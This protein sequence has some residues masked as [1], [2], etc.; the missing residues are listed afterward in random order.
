M[1]NAKKTFKGKTGAKPSKAVKKY[2]KR[3]MDNDKEDKYL[4]LAQIIAQATA[5]TDTT[6][7][8]V[9]LSGM[10]QGLTFATR[11][12]EVI[13][14]KSLEFRY[15]TRHGGG[16]AG[17]VD[18]MFR[19]IVFQD[20]QIRTSTLPLVAD[21]LET[22]VYNSPLNHIMKNASRFNILHDSLH[23]LS[24]ISSVTGQ[25]ES[26]FQSIKKSFKLNNK[27]VYTNTSTGTERNNVYVMYLSSGTTVG[28]PTNSPPINFYSRLI[29]EDA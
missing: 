4:D 3:V 22:V 28:T 21:I 10:S 24:P 20:R 12:G 16:G 15:D 8:V 17:L 9:L 26:S 27:I 25:S 1:V 14:A 6:G 18:T 5:A 19:I 23:Q 2:V 7:S 11:I 29:F 13:N